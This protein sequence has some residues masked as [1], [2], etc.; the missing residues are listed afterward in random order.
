MNKIHFELIWTIA[1]YWVLQGFISQKLPPFSLRSWQKKHLGKIHSSKVY[2]CIDKLKERFK[3]RVKEDGWLWFLWFL[4]VFFV[5]F[6]C[7]YINYIQ[8]SRFVGQGEVIGDVEWNVGSTFPGGQNG[9]KAKLSTVTAITLVEECAAFTIFL[10]WWH[11]SEPEFCSTQADGGDMKCIVFTRRLDL[12][13]SWAFYVC[14]RRALQL[15][16]SSGFLGRSGTSRLI[17]SIINRLGFGWEYLVS[18][19]SC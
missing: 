18:L 17:W 19:H 6:F 12:F 10:F 15:L 16:V 1:F 13:G 3:V 14:L 4:C 5:F 9:R 8:G 2:A 11:F 7:D